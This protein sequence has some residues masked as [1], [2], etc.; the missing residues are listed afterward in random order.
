MKSPVACDNGTN[1]PVS[2]PRHDL[3]AAPLVR[4]LIRSLFARAPS[5]FLGGAGIVISAAAGPARRG[6]ILLRGRKKLL[7]V[8]TKTLDDIR[9]DACNAILITITALGTPAV[10]ASLLRGIEQGW[11]PVMGAHVGLLLLLAW[12]TLHRR[13]LSLSF[14]AVAVTGFPLVVAIGGLLTYGRGNGVVMFLISSCVLAGCFFGRRAALGLVAGC[15]FLLATIYTGFRFGVLTLPVDPTSYDMSALSWLALGTSV[16][17][18]GAAPIIGLSALVQSLEVERRRADEAATIRQEFLAN[19]SH[20]LRTPMAGIIGMAEALR[21][22]LLDAQQQAVVTNLIGSGRNFLVVLNDLLDFSKFETG[23]VPIEPRP[24][25]LSEMIQ[26]VAAA[27]E[28]AAAQKGIDFRNEMP[29]G[30]HDAVVGDS[31]RIGQALANVVDNAIKFTERGSV[32]VRLSQTLREDGMLL[33]TCV[34]TDTGIGISTEPIARIFEPFIQGDMST[35]R[36]HGGSGLG[37]S[38]SR[39]LIDAMGGDISVT[40]QPGEGSAFKISVPLERLGLATTTAVQSAQPTPQTQELAG[41]PLRILVA[42][43]D[44][45]MR[46]LADIMLSRRGHLLTIAEDGRAALEAASKHA[47][48]CFILDMHMPVVDGREVMRVLRRK[49]PA[50][51]TVKRTPI[52]ALTADVVP[53]HVRAFLDAGADAVVAKPVEW[54]MLEAKIR[55]LTSQR[56]ST[57]DKS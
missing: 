16:V 20:E 56:I 51:H 3:A 17:A 55:Q 39:T 13:S 46:I 31:F 14:R 25:Q 38:I 34:V 23:Q 27:F 15:V 11:K 48:D 18:A 43:D 53:E 33:L 40:T 6:R 42:E 19:M 41:N 28:T 32:V 7:K 36:T 12:T 26:S 57:S 45:N 50:N 9:S 35:S 2:G 29:V 24:F 5:G 54:E 4:Q 37:L 10:G 21:N 30:F 52:I 22:T 8:D 44:A 47:Y 1:H 49:G